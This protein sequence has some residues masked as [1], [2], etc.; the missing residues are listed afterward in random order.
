MIVVTTEIDGRRRA[1]A[2]CPNSF[3]AL[4]LADGRRLRMVLRAGLVV[5]GTV[6]QRGGSAV[7][8]DELGYEYC[9]DAYRG[10]LIDLERTTAEAAGIHAA[11]GSHG[12]DAG[13]CA[14]LPTTASPSLFD[15][16]GLVLGPG[17]DAQVGY[18]HMQGPMA[19]AMRG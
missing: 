1:L 8:L 12:G 10:S 5:H 4:L 13:D 17:G 9:L 18:L 16:F 15:S 7:L 11:S 2:Y 14:N 3:Q 19:D 6:R